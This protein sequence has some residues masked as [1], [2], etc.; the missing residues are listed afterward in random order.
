MTRTVINL[1]DE[2]LAQASEIFGT[3]TKVSTVHAALKEAV[4]RRGRQEFLDWLAGG[5]L[6]DLADEGL[7]EQMWR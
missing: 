1:D 4:D 7:R 3:T 2:L 6:P 5:N